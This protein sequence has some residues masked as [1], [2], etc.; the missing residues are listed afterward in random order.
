MLPVHTVITVYGC[1]FVPIRLFP[2]A[3]V[4]VW[5]F[6]VGLFVAGIAFERQ[7]TV[8]IDAFGLLRREPSRILHE[9]P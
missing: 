5:L 9:F 6:L 8:A 3:C 1:G 2:L 7:V 4:L